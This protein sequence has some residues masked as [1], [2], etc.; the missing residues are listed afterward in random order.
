MPG[1][2]RPKG[3][4][5]LANGPTGAG[6]ACTSCA[7]V[8]HSTWVLATAA[9]VAMFSTKG[10]GA[11]FGFEWPSPQTPHCGSIMNTAGR[12]RL[13]KRQARKHTCAKKATRDHASKISR[14][15]KDSGQS[16]TPARILLNPTH[17]G[18]GGIPSGSKH[19]QCGAF[20]KSEP[21]WWDVQHRTDGLDETTH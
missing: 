9:A 19:S 4:T 13:Q 12:P 21:P 6:A 14:N 15:T 3:R 1:S 2:H 5:T 16:N 8:A 18:Q 10:A 17:Q 20:F 11:T 7:G